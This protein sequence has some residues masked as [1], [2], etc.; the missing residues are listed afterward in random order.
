MNNFSELRL[1]HL[2]LHR[3]ALI[4]LTLDV[5]FFYLFSPAKIPIYLGYSLTS[6][7]QSLRDIWKAVFW[8][9]SPQKTPWIKHNSQLLVQTKELSSSEPWEE[10]GMHVS[11]CSSGVRLCDPVHCDLPGSSVHG[12]LQARILEWV[13][14]P[15]SRGSSWSKDQTQVSFV[16]C[17]GRQVLY[18]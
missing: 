9:V 8:G 13:A 16:S 1:L 10:L 17:L 6:S 2:P 3:K 7:K 4:S 11:S 15:T 5:L 12:F 14:V 18:H